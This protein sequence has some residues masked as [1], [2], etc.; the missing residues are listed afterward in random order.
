MVLMVELIIP[1]TVTV[2]C[3]SRQAGHVEGQ[4]IDGEY[5]GHNYQ[6]ASFLMLSPDLDENIAELSTCRWGKI[7]SSVIDK[8]DPKTYLR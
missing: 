7:C 3:L 8:K 5:I 2:V 6:V 4:C 1:S